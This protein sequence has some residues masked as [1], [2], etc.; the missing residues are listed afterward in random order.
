MV[1]PGCYKIVSEPIP[2][3]DVGVC[4]FW[5]HRGVCPFALAIPW[6]TTKTLCLHGGICHIPHWIG[7][8]IHDT[9]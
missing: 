8:K 7:E 6:D 2:N 9:I 1:G 5:P 4:Y 3:L